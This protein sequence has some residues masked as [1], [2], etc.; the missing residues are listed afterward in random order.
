MRSLQPQS[1]GHPPPAGATEVG[2]QD[3]SQER[4][5]RRGP[6]SGFTGAEAYTVLETLLKISIKLQIPV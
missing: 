5:S 1:W 4:N 2:A 3:Q 6:W